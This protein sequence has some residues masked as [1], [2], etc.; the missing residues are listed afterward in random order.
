MS[1][2]RDPFAALAAPTRRAVL[3]LLREHETLTAGEIAAR[4]PRISRAAVSQHLTVLRNA[5]LV[6]AR[7]L[8]RE[9]HYRLDPAPLADIY[10]EWLAPFAPLWDES[11][12][13]LKRRVEEGGS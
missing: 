7:Q 4:F 6:R 5:R 11:L 8:G 3:D 13:A 9:W 10:N 12:Q 1:K 2:R